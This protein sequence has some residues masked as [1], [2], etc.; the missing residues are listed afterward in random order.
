MK[1][2][3][4]PAPDADEMACDRFCDRSR[5]HKNRRRLRNDPDMLRD[6]S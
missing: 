3:R 2:G 5:C 1:G 6:P 4:L